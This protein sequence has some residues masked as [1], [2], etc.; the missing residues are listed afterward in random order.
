[1]QT[2]DRLHAVGQAL[3]GLVGDARACFG[4][5][6]TSVTLYGTAA[7]D[8]LRDTSDVNVLFVFVTLDPAVLERFAPK[9]QFW[10]AAAPISAMFLKESEISAAV[11]LFAQKFSDIQRRHRV[12]YGKDCFAG[13]KPSRESTVLRLRQ[14]LLNLT[15]RIRESFAE[16]A[17]QPDRLAGAVAD[18]ASP[19][20]ACA[21]T[22]RELKG[23]ALLAPKEALEQFVGGADWLGNISEAR[24]KHSLTNDAAVSTMKGLLATAEA[25]RDAVE[26][27]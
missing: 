14:V 27:L 23:Q 9:L 10:R 3:D 6:L 2:A 1:M 25:M 11:E 18:F 19:L 17:S 22:L 7:E 24:L 8:R 5:D 20:R 15:L 12:L 13:I 16:R 26:K 21:A 4:A